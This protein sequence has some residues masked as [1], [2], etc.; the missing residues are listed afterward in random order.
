MRQRTVL[1]KAG[2][3]VVVYTKNLL[4]LAYQTFFD[5]KALTL[6]HFDVVAL[7]DNDLVRGQVANNLRTVFEQNA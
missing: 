3:E 2:S 1:F 7:H 6:I 4:H 5:V